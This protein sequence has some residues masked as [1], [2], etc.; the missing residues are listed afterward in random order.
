MEQVFFDEDVKGHRLLIT[1]KV[2]SFKGHQLATEAIDT[3]STAF[4]RQFLYLI[5]AGASYRVTLTT[6][7]TG[8]VVEF[9]KL[10]GLLWGGAGQF[11]RVRN[12]VTLA[13][14]HRLVTEAVKKLIDGEVLHFGGGNYPLERKTII[15]VFADGILI[16]QT[17]TLFSNKSMPV[18]WEHLGTSVEDGTMF[19]RCYSTGKRAR[20]A[21]WRMP[22]N[23]VFIGLINLLMDKAN[24]RMLVEE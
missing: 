17:G 14:G 11:K 20:V 8:V 7:G 16:E 9:A 18:R 3:V 1:S 2:V 5:P 19:F 21:V 22:N 12:A 15:K 13:A 6:R 4:F 23:V 10:G 24:Y